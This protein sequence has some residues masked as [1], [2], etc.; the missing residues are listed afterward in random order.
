MRASALLERESEARQKT[1]W[2]PPQR[3]SQL[4][5]EVVP[6]FHPEVNK[7]LNRISHGEDP[8]NPGH[9]LKPVVLAK[10]Q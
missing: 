8:E 4:D 9:P 6:N 3:K 1:P 2:R 10:A 5:D 7:L